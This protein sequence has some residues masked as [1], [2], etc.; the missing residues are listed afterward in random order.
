M[1]D[2]AFSGSSGGSLVAVTLSTGIPVESLVERVLSCRDICAMKLWKL[3]PCAEQALD[4]YLPKDAHTKCSGRLQVL[5]TKV[6]R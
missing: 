5:L 3:L 1:S 4:E 2:V 6:S